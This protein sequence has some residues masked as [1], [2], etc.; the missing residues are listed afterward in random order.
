MEK[1]THA[2]E[3]H[4]EVITAV[5]ETASPETTP[6][7]TS[8][9][10]VPEETD[11]EDDAPQSAPEAT[12]PPETT[13]ADIEARIAEAETRGYLRGRNES[14]AEHLTERIFAAFIPSS[15]CNLFRDQVFQPNDRIAILA[16]FA[17][18]LMFYSDIAKKDFIH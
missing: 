18:L 14:I 17:C 12:E 10:D 11:P 1:P 15:Q 8:Q 5:E 4:Q 9:P 2:E 7:Q 13:E 6:A 16:A 3:T